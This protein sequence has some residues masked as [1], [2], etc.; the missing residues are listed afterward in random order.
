MGDN[1]WIT[2]SCLFQIVMIARNIHLLLLHTQCRARHLTLQSQFLFDFF[3]SEAYHA[4][5]LAASIA[6]AYEYTAVHSDAG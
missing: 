4:S 2:M 5:E 3:F 6:I 1:T